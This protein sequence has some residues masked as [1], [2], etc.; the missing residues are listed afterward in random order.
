MSVPEPKS[1]T[2]D[3][4]LMSPGLTQAAIVKSCRP[5]T[6]PL[7]SCTYCVLVRSSESALPN[8]PGTRPTVTG[9]GWTGGGATLTGCTSYFAA[10]MLAC[11]AWSTESAG[12]PD[13][14]T[15]S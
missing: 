8:L 13:V 11:T 4:V 12:N 10:V 9:C 7:G 5:L 2:R 3:H 1:N 15:P 6:I 14:I